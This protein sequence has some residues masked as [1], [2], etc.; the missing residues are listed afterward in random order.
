MVARLTSFSV[1]GSVASVVREE[2][3][4]EKK[5]L[6]PSKHVVYRKTSV[7]GII[8]TL[9]ATRRLKIMVVNP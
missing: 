4:S 7:L 5:S 8:S 2:E 3:R 1:R 9:I 6:A